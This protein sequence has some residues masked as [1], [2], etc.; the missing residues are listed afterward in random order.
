MVKKAEKCILSFWEV[1]LVLEERLSDS[2]IQKIRNN[3]KEY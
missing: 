1:N 2:C 3:R